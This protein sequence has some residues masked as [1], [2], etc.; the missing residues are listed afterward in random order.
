MVHTTHEVPNS[1]ARLS[2]D[3]KLAE[4]SDFGMIPEGALLKTAIAP[5]HPIRQQQEHKP[6]QKTSSVVKS[7]T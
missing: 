5:F 4:A 1:I 7:S 3:V 2:V 6:G